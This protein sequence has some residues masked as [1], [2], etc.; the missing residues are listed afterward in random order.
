[1]YEN[2]TQ[3]DQ[4]G[5]DRQQADNEAKRRRQANMAGQGQ[6]PYAQQGSQEAA[7]TGAASQGAQM[8]NQAKQAASAPQMPQTFAQMQAAGQARPAPPMPPA[9]APGMPQSAG[10]GPNGMAPL[11]NAMA[12]S[13]N[14]QSPAAPMPYA[15]PQSPVAASGQPSPIAGSSNVNDALARLLGS[16]SAYQSKDVMATYNQLG[17]QID[18]QFNQQVTGV[19]EEMA[20]RG[21]Y[22]STIAG[23]RL[24]DTEVGR[25]SAKT[26]L[27]QD[28]A[29]QQAEK[30]DSA[31]QAAIGLGLQDQGQRFN[32]QDSAA[33]RDLQRDSLSMDNS[34][35][36]RALDQSGSQFDRNLGEQSRQFDKG[37]EY[38]YSALSQNGTMDLLRLLGVDVTAFGGE[39]TS[40]PQ[41]VLY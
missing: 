36:N 10:M 13:P 38:N 41:P 20:R 30:Y 25:R 11:M 1:M 5:T 3:V 23:G 31:N 15:A 12:S 14:T 17:S 9:P 18:D 40:A 39:G 22:D 16:P 35:R 7:L 26:S 27:A 28:L 32:Q 4:Q 2:Q 8:T 37:Q 29:R 24:Y 33:G 6:Y 19:N 34:Y 21:L